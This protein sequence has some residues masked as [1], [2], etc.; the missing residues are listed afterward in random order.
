LD[1]TEGLENAV[2]AQSMVSLK[3]MS[4]VRSGSYIPVVW[5]SQQSDPPGE[6]PRIRF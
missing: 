2:K 3:Y 1:D 5:K 6:L 4:G